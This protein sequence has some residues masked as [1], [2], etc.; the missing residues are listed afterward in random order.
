MI[1]KPFFMLIDLVLATYSFIVLAAVIMSW[2]IGFEVIN[3]RNRF[4][5]QVWRMATSLTE[6]ILAPIRRNLPS[7][8]SVDVSALVLLIGIWFL[9]QM[10]LWLAQKIAF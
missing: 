8:G 3:R 5:D 10:N 1:P 6:P 9:R 7:F 4:V 2:L